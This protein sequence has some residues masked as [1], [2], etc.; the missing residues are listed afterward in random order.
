MAEAARAEERRQIRPRFPTLEERLKERAKTGTPGT[1]N[2]PL[3]APSAW[4]GPDHV[5][6]AKK[7][8]SGEG[9]RLK[10]STSDERGHMPRPTQGR[11]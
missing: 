4:T 5:H 10:K 3:S 1:E 8:R 11:R 7:R 9:E 6:V 2:E